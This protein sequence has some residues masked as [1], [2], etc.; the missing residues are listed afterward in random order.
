MF[1]GAINEDLDVSPTEYDREYAV[2]VFNQATDHDQVFE[3]S[4]RGSVRIDLKFDVTPSHI[5][6]VIEYA[7]YEM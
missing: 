3:V 4:Q 1:G 5:I 7:E 6:N 2:Y